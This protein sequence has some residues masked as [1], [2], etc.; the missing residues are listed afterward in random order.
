[1]TEEHDE[2]Q[3]KVAYAGLL[4]KE[5]DPFKAALSLFPNNTNRALWVA[6]HWPVDPEVKEAQAKLTAEGGEMGF[7]PDK[8]ELA[9]DI[10]ERMQGTKTADGR[11]IS[12]TADEYSKLAKLYADVRGFIEKP[13]NNQNVTV[14]IPK[15]IEVPTHGTNEEWEQAA[16][17]QQQDLLNVSRSRH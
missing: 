9:R 2:S 17:K 3:E 6:N 14:V 8:A 12:P 13:Q 1:M 10:W 5:R 11:T 7:L 15:A 4:L 16:A